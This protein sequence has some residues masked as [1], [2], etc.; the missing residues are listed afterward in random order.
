MSDK[1][2]SK[3]HETL[4][5]VLHIRVLRADGLKKVDTIGWADGY[6]IIKANGTKIGKNAHI[7]IYEIY[8]K[9]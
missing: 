4:H 8:Q 3:S 9:L 6:V 2:K 1:K 7:F 5:Q